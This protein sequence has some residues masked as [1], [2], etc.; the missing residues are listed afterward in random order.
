MRVEPLP[1][2]IMICL[3]DN[4]R[5]RSRLYWMMHSRHSVVQSITT[6]TQ[7]DVTVTI[8]A[9]ADHL[10]V[11]CDGDVKADGDTVSIGES[12]YGKTGKLIYTASGTKTYILAVLSEDRTTVENTM[13]FQYRVGNIDRTAPTA[14]WEPG[15]SMERKWWRFR[16]TVL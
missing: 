11:K 1:S 2:P 10:Y 9:L 8:S 5:K 13:T 7:E 14:V 6:S 4:G 3:P 15:C 12:T 16:K